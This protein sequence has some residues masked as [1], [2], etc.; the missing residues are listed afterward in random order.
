MAKEEFH[1]VLTLSAEGDANTDFVSAL[2]DGIS[3]DTV[4]SDSYE[5][6]REQREQTDLKEPW[7]TLSKVSRVRSKCSGREMAQECKNVLTGPLGRWIF[8]PASG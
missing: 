2:G 6:Q 7:R 3:H 1:D 4:N 8:W 5:G